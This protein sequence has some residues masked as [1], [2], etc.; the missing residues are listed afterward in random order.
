MF[1]KYDGYQASINRIQPL[2]TYVRCGAH[3]THLVTARAA[4]TS[5]SLSRCHN[6]V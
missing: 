5:N 6:H 2:D 4:Q 3:A 1:G